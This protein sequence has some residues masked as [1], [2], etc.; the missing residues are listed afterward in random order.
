MGPTYTLNLQKIER[1][2]KTWQPIWCWGAGQLAKSSPPTEKKTDSRATQSQRSSSSKA[3]VQESKL[4]LT[5]QVRNFS[6]TIPEEKLRRS[7][8]NCFLIS[9]CCNSLMDILWQHCCTHRPLVEAKAHQTKFI[10]NFFKPISLQPK[11]L[12]CS[13]VIISDSYEIVIKQPHFHFIF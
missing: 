4:K 9:G 2:K 7:S 13:S 12:M 3:E 11:Y 5:V 10:H 8:H 1:E 6:L